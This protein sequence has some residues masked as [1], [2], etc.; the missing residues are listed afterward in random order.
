VPHKPKFQLDIYTHVRVGA[1][2]GDMPMSTERAEQGSSMG[3]EG[4]VYMIAVTTRRPA[5]LTTLAQST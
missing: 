1:L 2:K 4:S 5:E 3:Q